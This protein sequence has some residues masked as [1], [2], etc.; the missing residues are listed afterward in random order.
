MALRF[1]LS[2]PTVSTV[3]PGMR[4]PKHVERNIAVSDG[5]ALPSAAKL[6]L[7]KHRWDR[8]HVIP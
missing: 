2:D 8:T 6:V 3:I 4:K 5:A 7:R 1:V